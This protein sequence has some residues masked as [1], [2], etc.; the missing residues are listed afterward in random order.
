[1]T[2]RYLG[3]APLCVTRLRPGTC[4]Q[5]RISCTRHS[6]SGALGSS[7][8]AIRCGLLSDAVSRRVSGETGQWD[9]GSLEELQVTDHYTSGGEL[10]DVS[11]TRITFC[12]TEFQPP[13]H[14]RLQLHC[15][16]RHLRPSLCNRKNHHEASAGSRAPQFTTARRAGFDRLHYISFS[17]MGD[18]SFAS[19]DCMI[20]G[21]LPPF[22]P[23][24]TS[25]RGFRRM[26]D[27]S[28][29]KSCACHR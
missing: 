10:L 24:I 16:P 5:Y 4:A 27:S 26:M 28:H 1:M 14:V 15:C 9:G 17:W 20:P 19:H 22:M 2:P 29:A 23:W 12:P 11:P 3:R 6:A 8:A 21:C 7:F 18:L 13:S 25:C